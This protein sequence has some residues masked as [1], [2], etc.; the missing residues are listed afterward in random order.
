MTVSFLKLLS[1]LYNYIIVTAKKKVETLKPKITQS[2]K[3]RIELLK[4]GNFNVLVGAVRFIQCKLIY[5]NSAAS[6]EL[7]IS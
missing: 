6:I 7:F 4:E 3:K 1:K 2:L 5:Q